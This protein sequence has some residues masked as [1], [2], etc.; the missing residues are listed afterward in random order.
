MH[1]VFCM[2]MVEKVA[3]SPPIRL[4]TIP[5]P[6]F[7]TTS[8]FHLP[9]MWAQSTMRL[10]WMPAL[11]GLSRTSIPVRNFATHRPTVPPF[12][13]PSHRFHPFFAP[14]FRSFSTATL[15]SIS[16]PSVE[17]T[18]VIPKSL[19]KWLFGCSAL[20]FG[21]LVVGGLTRLTESGLSITEWNL[22]T[23]VLPPLTK[24][25]WDVEWEKYKVSPEGV[26]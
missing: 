2:E 15:S 22:V 17:A 4:A 7:S 5:V 14:S 23:G 20:V 8:L 9:I 3:V 24:A 21:I 13:A 1:R 25:D 26:L 6:T 11:R 10:P 16:T 19:P 12:F 18:R